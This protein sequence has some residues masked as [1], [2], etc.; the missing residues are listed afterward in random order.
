M[1]ENGKVVF[2]WV[3]DEKYKKQSIQSYI[4]KLHIDYIATRPG[5]DYGEDEHGL[6]GYMKE[7]DDVEGMNL[8]SIKKYVCAQ[9]RVCN[10][11]GGNPVWIRSNQPPVASFVLMIVML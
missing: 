3:M 6:F 7:S 11:T 9:Q 5:T 4:N 8:Q 2:K 10:L 1:S